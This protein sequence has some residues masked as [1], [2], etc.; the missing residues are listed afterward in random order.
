MRVRYCIGGV[1]MNQRYGEQRDNGESQQYGESQRQGR[2]GQ[3]Q[4]NPQHGQHRF[5][6]SERDRE[7]YSREGFAGA[8]GGSEQRYGEGGWG[9]QEDRW[10]RQEDRWGR[11]SE[12]QGGRYGE[13]QRGQ[14]YYPGGR[15]GEERDRD[16]ERSAY[17]GAMSYRDADPWGRESGRPYFG[18]R[19]ES[20]YGDQREGYG[21]SGMRSPYSSGWEYGQRQQGQYGQERDRESGR[22]RGRGLLSRL[23]GRGPKGYKRSDDRI[24]EDICEQLWRSDA[25]DSSEVTVMVSEGVVTLSGTVPERWMR[26]EL[27]NVADETMGVKDIDNNIRIQRQSEDTRQETG[28]AARGTSGA[29]TSTSA[30]STKQ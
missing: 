17:W 10:G 2:Y 28:S 24:K 3:G 18:R 15:F 6:Q 4:Q 23:F 11:Q 30:T 20:G 8:Q 21:A 26:H 16:Y 22:G 5:G 27:E 7:G 25:I 14:G 1:R 29:G 12:G 13:N 19:E 9:R